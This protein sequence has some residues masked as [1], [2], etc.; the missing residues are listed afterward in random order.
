M[1]NES[2]PI[3][4]A[5]L[6]ELKAIRTELQSLRAGMNFQSLP[7]HV[8]TV[9]PL[10]S[11]Q[12]AEAVPAPPFV[13]MTESSVAADEES[14]LAVYDW[15]NA[16]GITVKN[17]H[18]QSEADTVFD[19]LAVFLGD[20]FELLERLHDSIRRNLSTGSSFTL[21]LSSS[22]QEEIAAATQFCTMLSSYAFLSA[23]KYNKYTKTIYAAPQ[24]V[25]KV[26]NFF[27]GGW[28]ERYIYLKIVS[29]LIGSN[30]S[31]TCLLNPQITFSNGDE[32]ELDLLFLVDG[33]PLWVECKTSDY[34]AY[35]AK[36]SDTRK[37]LAVPKSRSILVIL[38]IPNEL[39]V[40]L[41]R[42]YDITV[43]NEHNFLEKVAAAVGLAGS[44]HESASNGL[45]ALVAPVTPS[46]LST[47]LN[48]AGLRPLPEYRRQAINELIAVSRSL[49]QPATLVEVKAVLANRLQVSKNQLQDLLNAMIR[50]GC[51]LDNEG[52]AVLS[53]TTPF[54]KLISDDPE[55][56]ERKCIESYV[57]AVLQVDPTY[58]ESPQN[59]GEFERIVGGK[60]PDI[61]TI[62][63]LR[64]EL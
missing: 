24:R 38:G 36:Y 41:T 46:G 14:S 29:F 58:F 6:Q 27:T 10:P 16:K 19:Q 20:R 56:I 23:Y 21:N 40:N 37:L 39:T 49:D 26:I 13:Q 4:E 61:A 63:A 9:S 64:D 30:L 45:S 22:R 18:E 43:A 32:F 60:A 50:S 28:F 42:L 34:Q 48:K 1:N 59:I 12:A 62:K 31:Y 11:E 33:Q 57:R 8:E 55:V 7:R 44:E 35:I 17:Y 54:S 53:F 51:L 15:L 25:G 47:L 5:I 3:L 52:S 2:Q